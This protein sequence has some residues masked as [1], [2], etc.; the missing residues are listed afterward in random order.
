MKTK[1]IKKIGYYKL[2]IDDKEINKKYNYEDSQIVLGTISEFADVGQWRVEDYR[3]KKNSIP[4]P[5]LEDGVQAYMPKNQDEVNY[6]E[7][8]LHTF[9]IDE[10]TG[11]YYWPKFDSTLYEGGDHPCLTDPKIKQYNSVARFTFQK[12][13]ELLKEQKSFWETC[14]END[15]TSSRVKINNPMC[16]MSDSD[17]CFEFSEAKKIIM[18]MTEKQDLE[19]KKLK[20]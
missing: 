16:Q 17:V 14:D 13:Y 20:P 7:K 4:S 10:K 5:Y 19:K 1:I 6:L 11:T 2:V 9:K 15:L 3:L 8:N 12:A 18:E